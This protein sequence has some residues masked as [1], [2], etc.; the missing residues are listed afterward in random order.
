MLATWTDSCVV[1][2]VCEMCELFDFDLIYE[3][4]HQVD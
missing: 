4:A 1:C 3:H 2:F